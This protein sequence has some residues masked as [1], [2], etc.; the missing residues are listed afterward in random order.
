MATASTGRRLDFATFDV[1]T[2]TRLEGN[3]LAIV[4][5]PRYDDLEQNLKQAIAREFN[6]SETVFLHEAEDDSTPDRRIDIFTTTAEL[7]FAGHPT[8]GSIC[9]VGES[10]TAHGGQA[11]ILRTKAGSIRSKYD[12]EHGW[13]VASIPHNVHIHTNRLTRSQVES[14]HTS[15][16]ARP[17]DDLL[18]LW[19][20]GSK[21]SFF[22]FPVVSI[23]KRMTFIL[24]ALPNVEHYLQKLQVGRQTKYAEAIALDEGWS[25]S[26]VAPY[27][28]TILS[29]DK[30]Q[31]TKIRTRMIEPQIGEDPATGSAAC[32]LGSYLALQSDE[33]GRTYRFDI[34]QGIEMGR[35]SEIGVDVTLNE[36]GTAVDKVLLSGNAVKVTEG[37]LML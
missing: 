20:C 29:E 23:V 32:T 4:K 19:P 11:F 6:F 28:Y 14:L 21:D 30:E 18:D 37:T 31:P 5:V 17:Q 15:I 13:A 10:A 22:E 1:F 25:P 26:F 34:V 16:E 35:A 12:R 24:I 7:P 33:G 27:F 9:C 8:I 36:S 2:Q 3:P